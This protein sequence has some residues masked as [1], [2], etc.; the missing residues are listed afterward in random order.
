MSTKNR[1]LSAFQIR[2]SK[3]HRELGEK[4]K[5]PTITETKTKITQQNYPIFYL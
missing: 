5:R 3:S 4:K 1:E 2:E